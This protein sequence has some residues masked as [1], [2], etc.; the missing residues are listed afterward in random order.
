MGAVSPEFSVEEGLGVDALSG[1]SWVGVNDC[2]TALGVVK[3]VGLLI[4]WN[5][6]SIEV[7]RDGETFPQ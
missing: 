7:K 5:G 2:D 4:G 3:D 6:G 1:E